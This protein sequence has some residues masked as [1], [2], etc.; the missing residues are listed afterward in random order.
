ML[1]NVEG[2]KTQS[3][4][5]IKSKAIAIGFKGDYV[6]EKVKRFSREDSSSRAMGRNNGGRRCESLPKE[7]VQLLP[8]VSNISSIFY[9]AC[10]TFL[11]AVLRTLLFLS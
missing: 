4:T 5:R 7:T 1:G 11:F 3:P 6:Q 2:N 8:Q 10:P 9:T